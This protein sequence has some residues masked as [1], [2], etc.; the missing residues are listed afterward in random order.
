MDE[1]ILKT[2]WERFRSH[3]DLTIM[4][5][6]TLLAPYTKSTIENLVILSDGCANSNFRVTF[7][8]N[9]KPVVLRIY[10]R[11]EI[12]ISREVAIH[13]LV[14]N[15]IPIP[16]ILYADGHCKIFQYPY[17]IMEWVDG[18]L[19]REVI[20]K[21]EEQ[22]ISD[23]SF[24]AGK[25][26]NILRQMTFSCGGFFQKELEVLPFRDEDKYLPFVLYLLSDHIVKE[27]LGS[28]LTHNV[29]D[30]VNTYS[31]IL[32]KENEANL[33]H[34]DYDPANMLVK[35]IDNRWKIVAILDWEFAFSGTYLM[36][37]GMMLRYSHKLPTCYETDFIAGI[38]ESGFHLPNNW[39]K[40]SKLMDLICL[41]NL[42]R[43]N[44]AS[45]RPNL[46][47]DVVSLIKH[48]VENWKSF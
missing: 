42:V 25:Y 27:N 14:G 12:A 48:T 1:P 23:C 45:E 7:K 4:K 44:P 21:K 8:N 36:D 29:M 16:A 18:T 9:D 43:F 19:M 10:M 2:H 41:L 47:R 22:A 30:L 20:L 17:A 39:K 34:A 33:T 46:N 11:D 26:L 31:D 28:V 32:P 38:Q 35:K 15:S 40:Q 6:A 24:E 13:K 3:V 37:M 5:A